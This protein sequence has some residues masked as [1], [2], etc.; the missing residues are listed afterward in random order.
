[1]VAQDQDLRFD[2]T[3]ND[4]DRMGLKKGIVELE[5]GE[6]GMKRWVSDKDG[7]NGGGKALPC[8]SN[9]DNAT[10]RATHFH[11][12]HVPDIHHGPP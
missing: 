10:F 4:L 6:A 5:R 3:G 2:G 7:L 1:M 11:V 12:P 8:P 9:P